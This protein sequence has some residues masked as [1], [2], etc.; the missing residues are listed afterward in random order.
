M[1]AYA[2]HMVNKEANTQ[3]LNKESKNQQKNIP[4]ATLRRNPE[5]TAFVP[6]QKVSFWKLEWL[7]DK[8][9]SF[10]LRW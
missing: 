7:L 2:W 3:Q 5:A 9:L 4:A 10:Y 1:A 8:E 6:S